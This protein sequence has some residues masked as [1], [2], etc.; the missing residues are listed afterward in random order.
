VIVQPDAKGNVILS[1]TNAELHGVGIQLETQGGLP[2]IGFWTSGDEWVFWKAQFP[3]AGAFKVSA[4]LAAMDADAD[5]V[6]EV[7]GQSINGQAPVTGG[8]D[9]FQTIE[10]GQIK[11]KLPGEL[12]VKVRAQDAVDWKPINLNSVRLTP[13]D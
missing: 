2:D 6:V 5:F 1:A 13:V 12:V 3:K 9:K 8:W 11:I 10:L 4:T 7:G